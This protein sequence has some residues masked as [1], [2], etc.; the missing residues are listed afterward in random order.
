MK[1]LDALLLETCV[2]GDFSRGA[3]LFDHVFDS[4]CLSSFLFWI[5]TE[6]AKMY[7]LVTIIDFTSYM[8]CH[9]PYQVRFEREVSNRHAVLVLELGLHI[10]GVLLATT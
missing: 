10:V 7:H 4:R 5:W 3:P 8:F 9:I 1:V 2:F 6:T